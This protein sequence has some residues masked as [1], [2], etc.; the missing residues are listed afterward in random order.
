M[1]HESDEDD[2][3][4][5]IDLKSL[6]A[7]RV[8]APEE[9]RK[10][11]TTRTPT[12]K[13]KRKARAEANPQQSDDSDACDNCDI[14]LRIPGEAVLARAQEDG[15][16]YPAIIESYNPK[17]GKYKLTYSTN[18]SRSLQRSDFHARFDPKFAIVE[19]G[20]I[21]AAE[22]DNDVPSPD[23][24][25]QDLEIEIRDVLPDIRQIMAGSHR[26]NTRCD[27]FFDG[28]VNTLEAQ[29]C[30]GPLNSDEAGLVYR[31]L[32]STFFE[33]GADSVADESTL[34]IQTS[35]PTETEKSVEFEDRAD[36]GTDGGEHQSPG[37]LPSPPASQARVSRTGNAEPH[38]KA[39]RAATASDPAPPATEPTRGTENPIWIPDA[40]PPAASTPSPLD[41]LRGKPL[42][43][44]KF[45][46]LVLVP[47]VIA[48]ILLA[49]SPDTLKDLQ[50]AEQEMIVAAR[51]A[52]RGYVKE[53]LTA[54]QCTVLGNSIVKDMQVV[55]QR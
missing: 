20:P 2:A 46:R 22:Y 12:R 50:D 29:L 23:Y 9:P 42:R 15:R 54:R 36:S 25:D 47:E 41:L 3:V 24:E 10:S 52:D 33:F 4:L 49:R 44:D 6:I 28:R 32:M 16:F 48:R 43:A 17:T 35:V 26:S 45:T 14:S 21:S 39:T 19:M 5:L 1:D 13:G 7:N 55:A 30:H 11:V 31:V 8:S 51:A 27:C 40:I 18:H 37:R 34:S 53:I 38:T